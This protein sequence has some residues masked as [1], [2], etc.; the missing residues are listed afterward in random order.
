MCMFMDAMQRCI[1]AGT[2]VVING[3]K[4]VRRGGINRG[5]YPPSAGRGARHRRRGGRGGGVFT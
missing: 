2:D 3:P 1:A 5:Q 4:T